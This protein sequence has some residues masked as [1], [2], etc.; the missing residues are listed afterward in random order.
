M[1][2]QAIDIAALAEDVVGIDGLFP[3]DGGLALYRLLA[4]GQPVP[5]ERLAARTDRSPNE[6]SDW[7]RGSRVE[8]DERG[9]VVALLGFS[10][11]PTKQILEIGG[12]ALYAWCAGDFESWRRGRSVL[13]R[14]CSW[15]RRLIRACSRCRRRWSGRRRPCGTGRWRAADGGSVRVLKPV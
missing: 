7:L 9:E 3:H 15:D 12:R 2:E 6:V 4:E 10:L 8:L 11:R 5:V 1:G 14:L 13:G